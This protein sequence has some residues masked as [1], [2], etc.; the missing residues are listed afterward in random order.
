MSEE[1]HRYMAT[2]D[3][4][5][6]PDAL[7]ADIQQDEIHR[8]RGKL[9]IFFGM[10]AGVG[11][12]YSMLET[13]RELRAEGTDV[14]VGYV[15]THGRVETEGFLKDLPLIPRKKIEYRGASMEEM[16]LDALVARH[17]KLALVDELAHTNVPGARHPKRYQDVL[18][19]L[20]AGIDVYTTINVQHLESRAD[21]VRQITGITV[22][23][24]VPD[25]I[26]EQANEIE[27]I[28]L[29]PE[30]LLKRLAEGKVYTGERADLAA[31]NFF[32]QGNLTALREMALRL[33][34]ERV[35]HQL[36]DYMQVKHIAGPWKS[37]ERLMVAVDASSLSE[38]LVRWTRRMAY[39][40]DAP[41]IAAYVE[42]SHTLTEREKLTLVR[43]TT[44]A[45]ELGA[46]VITTSDESVPRALLRIAHQR[47]VTQIVV[48]K[49]ARGLLQRYFGSAQV[50]NRLV[51]NSGDID[52]Y[53]VSGDK[54]E[55]QPVHPLSVL[56]AER[57]AWQQYLLALSIVAMT[58]VANLIVLPWFGYRAA[59]LVYLFI[60]AILALFINRGPVLL[61]AAI[62][63]ILWDYLF[64]PP[65][66][67]IFIYGL[68]DILTFIMYFIVAFTTGTLTARLRAQEKAVR[69]RE[70]RATAMY[71]LAREVASAVTMDDVLQ[72]AVKQI[73]QA[74]SVD[75]AFLL[76]DTAGRLSKQPHSCS[77]WHMSEKDFG[78][79]QL[80][81]EKRKAAGRYTD[82]LPLAE[83]QYLPLQAPDGVV[84]VMGIRARG[85]QRPSFDQQMLLETFARQ[86]ALAIERERL[87]E[88]AEH[89][90]VVMESERLYKTLL[91][92]VSHEL[93]TPIATI[94]G[95]ASSLLDA[96]T[97]DNVQAR[98]TLAQ[99]I[100][101]AADRLNR[102]VEN[103]LDM[104]RLDSGKLKL[105]LEWCDVGDLI[106]VVT[107]RIKGSLKAHEL[108]VDIPPDLPLIRVDFVL[109][110]QALV[111]LL[112][113]AAVHTPA[114]TRVRIMARVDGADLLL[115]VADR[116]PGLPPDDLERVF[117]KFYRAPG[118]APGGTGLGLSIT[119][120]LVEAQGG[121]VIAENRANGGAQFTIRIP[122]GNPPV[123][124]PEETI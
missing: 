75:V 2:Q 26:V 49:P 70:E 39:N 60:V 117:E 88:A 54:S 114:G 37:G 14:V 100:Q 46:E 84:G 35:D 110:E 34:A 31:H 99:E 116:G 69:S 20:D 22:H 98:T 77:T 123:V 23:E 101:T 85:S 25:S 30:E 93:R 47:N 58:T 53:I 68:E 74:F 67:T 41:W 71:A 51:R 82:T 10:A 13:A 89:T 5:P 121:T 107:N 33:T 15:E 111:N 94:T 57:S 81:F 19:L 73:G 109:L 52:I 8:K 108:I 106:S 86:I 96:R 29:A 92:S 17:P 87:E 32:R 43:A 119:K 63:A 12:T 78:V 95:A 122:I 104:T 36:Q 45:R 7:L 42:T 55:A 105:N 16:D 24:T 113:N 50:V 18:E 27:L 11:K 9:K 65:R 56:Q 1:Y 102:V 79:A 120:G 118:A 62:S 6:D 112:H 64:I 21:T 83:A 61:A 76:A 59:S 91:S 103:L 4:R 90:Y 3:N 28:D 80:A 44:L 66:F 97:G 38:R 72:T 124:P 48:G 115:I 40:L